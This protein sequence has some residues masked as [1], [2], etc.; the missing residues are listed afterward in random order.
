MAAA[1]L[2]LAALCALPT[3]TDETRN[4][5]YIAFGEIVSPHLSYTEYTLPGTQTRPTADRSLLTDGDV[6]VTAYEKRST[7]VTAQIEAKT[8][9]SISLPLFG[10]DGYRAQVNGEE[11]QWTLGENNRLTVLLPAGTEGEL[12]VW[13]AGKTLW[14]IAEGISLAT[15]L[16]L[17]CCWMRKRKAAS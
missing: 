2:A 1:I 10:F 17:T 7:T 9:A 14:R 4:A 15:L 3:L 11:I 8:D 6:T 5:D 16:A 12:S 13:F